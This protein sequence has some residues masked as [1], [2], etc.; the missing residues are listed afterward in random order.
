MVSVADVVHA[1]GG[2]LLDI[3]VA[4][5]GPDVH[6]VFVSDPAD[7]LVGQRGDLVLGI[8]LSAP[9]QSVDLLRRCAEGD[10][11]GLVLRSGLATDAEVTAAARQVGLP[12]L[13]VADG[14]SWAHLVWLMREIL[15]R[16]HAP[17]ISATDGPGG[18]GDLFALAD[19][20]AAIVDAPVTIEDSQSRVL[21]YSPGQ[22]GTDPARVSTIVGRRV[23]ED[24]VS[25]FRARGVFRRLAGSSE[26]F[27]VPER[28]DGTRPRLVVPVRAGGEWLGSIWAVVDGAVGQQTTVELRTVASVVALHLLHRRAQSDL[29]RRAATDRLRKALWQFEPGAADLDLPPGPWRVVELAGPQGYD[30][31]SWRLEMW[32]SAARRHGWATPLLADHDGTVFAVVTDGDGATPGSWEWLRTMVAS[33]DPEET[34]LCATAGG[35]ARTTADLPRS[36]AEASELLSL[37]ATGRV[38]GPSQTFEDAWDALTVNRATSALDVD[39]LPGPLA[40]LVAH[41]AQHDT[42]YV[43]TLQAWLAHHR[44]PREAARSLLVHPNTLRYRM[45]QLQQIADLDLHRP[46][47]RLAMQLQIEALA[48]GR[49]AT[50]PLPR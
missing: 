14:V 7:A 4:G 43:A 6:D 39:L 46:L 3:V 40:G 16:T 11:S 29:T 21:A 32:E 35:S 1:V 48:L 17:G 23:P 26:P 20:A 50:E 8:G 22:A 45:R 44:E 10:A 31:S 38:G 12:L 19:A 27:L 47:A 36:R 25:H 34:T 49:S 42:A 2:S 5:G 30:D 18:Q 33:M 37:I 9:A 13:G 28:P 24:L 15:E 41:D